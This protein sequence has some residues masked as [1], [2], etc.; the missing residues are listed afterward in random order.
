MGEKL[1]GKSFTLNHLV[2]TSFARSAMPTTGLYLKR[3]FFSTRRLTEY[4][5]GVWMSVSP[6]DDELIVALEFEGEFS[7]H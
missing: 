5:E 6:T 7:Y 4:L 1:V 2:G 3:Q